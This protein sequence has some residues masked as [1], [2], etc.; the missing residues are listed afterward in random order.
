[1]SGEGLESWLNNEANLNAHILSYEKE[2]SN[3]FYFGKILYNFGLLPNFLDHF[4][5]RPQAVY[6]ETHYDILKDAF[7]SIG[8]EFDENLQKSLKREDL[9]VAKKFLFK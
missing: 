4:S 5:N 6:R 9:G 1:M 3:G 8:I 2:F 7:K